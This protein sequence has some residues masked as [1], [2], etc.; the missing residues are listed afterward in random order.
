MTGRTAEDGT[1]A[2]SAFERRA[3]A[4]QRSIA[5]VDADAVV[6]FPSSNLYYLSGFTDEPMERHLLLFVT[7]DAV[8]YVVPDL[9]AEEVR[10]ESWV[11]DVRSWADGADPLEHVA[12]VREECGLAAGHLLVDDSMWATFSQDLRATFPDA[13]WGLASE[14]LGPLRMRKDEMEIAALREAGARSD[15]VCER[16]RELGTD[17]VGMTER[18]LA[19]LIETALLDE[20][21]SRPSFDVIVGSGPNGSKPHH[22]HGDRAIERGDPVVLDFGGVYDRYPGDQ[23]RTIVFDGEPPDGFEARFDAVR[24]ANRA[25]VEAVAPGV[26]AQEVD[27]AAREVVENAGF[28]DEFVHRTGHGVGLDV[29]EPPYVV[30]GNDRHLE[31]GMVFSVEPGVYPEGEYGVRIEDLVAVTENGCERLNDSPRTWKPL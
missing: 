31:P 7:E 23:T 4:C 27:R 19:Q 11:G 13:T 17:A 28:G 26:E 12:D 21:C 15:A 10:A 14:L 6:L 24:E 20:G 8:T 29:H 3:R 18:E 5:D 1:D 16:V 9:Y 22:R 25:G 30:D 2:G